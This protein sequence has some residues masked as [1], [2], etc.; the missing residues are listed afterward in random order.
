[1]SSIITAVF[2]ATIGMIVNRGRDAAAERLKEGD[3]ADQKFRGAIV[4]EIE[5]IKTKLD[6]LARKDLLPGI[7]A[8]ETGLGF[9]YQAIDEEAPEATT[10]RAERFQEKHSKE[11]SSPSPTVAAKTVAFAEKMKRMQ[12]NAF[13]DK[14]KRALYQANK[15]FKM[16]REEATRAFNNEAL[17]TFNRVTAIRYRV[18]STMLG[19]AIET[20]ATAGDLSTLSVENVLENALPECEQCLLKLNSL[21]DVQNNFKVEL[22]QGLLN[23]KGWFGKDERRQ[24]ISTV[25]QVNRAIYDAKKTL[26]KDRHIFIWP[27]VDTGEEKINPLRDER[28]AKV[29]KTVGTEHSCVGPLSFGQEGPEENRLSSPEGIAT[30][31]D[32]QFIVADNGDKTIKVFDIN[33]NFL[34]SF[35][36]CISEVG[37]RVS[38]SDVTTDENSS[39][40]VLDFVTPGAEDSELEVCFQFKVVSRHRKPFTMF[41]LA[42]DKNSNIYVL[43]SPITDLPGKDIELEVKVFNSTFELLLKFPAGSHNWTRLARMAVTKNKVLVSRNTDNGHVVDIYNHEGAFVLHFD[44]EIIKYADDITADDDGRM[45]ILNAKDSYIHVFNDDGEQLSKFYINTKGYKNTETLRIGCHPEGKHVVVVGVEKKENVLNPLVKHFFG[46]TIEQ[47]TGPLSAS[48]YTKD[49]K[50]VRKILHQDSISR[51]NAIAVTRKGHIA[52]AVDGTEVIVI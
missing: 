9:L 46:F 51:I 39:I 22:D 37:K 48:I 24:I 44:E 5:E 38:I 2:K 10:G 29:L 50:F 8:F 32:G 23:I 3:V 20:V 31:S 18:I 45:M 7:D 25:C 15:R 12:L 16:T 19:S 47:R 43:E 21:P 35:N 1:M 11:I 42:T 52:V 49:G 28:V 41:D 6:G 17:S 13:S 14:T 26:C 30:N 40:Y 34:L 36:T 27:L 4:R 33:G